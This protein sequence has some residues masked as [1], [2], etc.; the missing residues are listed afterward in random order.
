MESKI[1]KACGENK[2]VSKYGKN[3]KYKDSLQPKCKECIKNNISIKPSPI[4]DIKGEVWKIIPNTDS[5]YK[6]SNKGRIKSCERIVSSEGVRPYTKYESLL[7][8]SDNGSG[9]K[10]VMLSTP[11][12]KKSYRAYVHRLVM[13]SFVGINKLEVDHIDGDKSN[14]QLSNLRYCTSRENKHYYHN[15]NDSSSDY[16]GVSYLSKLNKYSAS[17]KIQR[18]SYN[19]G[20]FEKEEDACEK[21]MNVLDKWLTNKEIPYEKTFYGKRNPLTTGIIKSGNRYYYRKHYFYKV[22]FVNSF[23]TQKEAIKCKS[24]FDSLLPQK[25]DEELL[26]LFIDEFNNKFYK[27]CH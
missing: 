14:N 25:F 8:L 2:K 11:L 15:T 7:S 18:V 20:Y 9:Y 4:K 1:C 23:N 3:S 27:I 26:E 16:M 24:L 22:Y 5:L 6:A 12:R 17:I 10:T 13:E 21:Y 19:L